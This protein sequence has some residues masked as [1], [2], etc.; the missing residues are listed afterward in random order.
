MDEL[1]SIVLDSEHFAPN[2]P[3]HLLIP[4][5]RLRQLDQ[6]SHDPFQS[7]FGLCYS[8]LDHLLV[9]PSIEASETPPE[10]LSQN[11]HLENF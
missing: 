1:S 6:A 9:P 4:D 11:F 7:T 2:E 3:W 5:Q 10:F 8:K